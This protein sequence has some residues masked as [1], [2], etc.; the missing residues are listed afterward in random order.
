MKAVSYI[1]FVKRQAVCR[2]ALELV[3]DL[4]GRVEFR[5]VFRKPFGLKARV[6]QQ[7]LPDRRPF[8]DLAPVPQQD[9]RAGHVTQ[10]LSQERGHMHGLEVVLPETGIQ[11]DVPA[12][13]ADREGGQG[14]DAVV[15]VA[16][17]NPWS[18]T[19]RAPR[20]SARRNEQKAALIQ[21]GQMGPKFS[22]LFL[23]AATCIAS[24]VRRRPRRIA[25]A[26]V[27]APGR[28]TGTAAT[29]ATHGWGDSG[30]RI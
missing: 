12:D 28:T 2:V 17:G 15:L 25:R 10:K 5:G 26:S 27:P 7:H 30:R 4:F 22:R 11:S 9:D 21:E 29:A 19:L 14:R 20:P 8:V 16:V 13:R 24:S 23:Y 6:V 3:P 1:L 18:L